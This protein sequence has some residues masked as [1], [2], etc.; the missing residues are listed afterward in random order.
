MPSPPPRSTWSSATPSSSRS[1][2]S[3]TMRAAALVRGSSDVIWEPTW[4]CTPTGRSPSV[5]AA[6][7]KRARADS[8]GTPNLLVRSPVEM[9]GWLRASMSGFTRRAT[10]ALVRWARARPP[11]RS[12]SPGDSALI[13]CTPSTIARSSS[14]GRLA[15]AGEDDAGWIEPGSK[16]DFDLPDGVC[17]GPAAKLAQQ[18]RNGQRR[19][20]LERIVE[21]VR[22]AAQCRVQLAVGGADRR[23]IVDV[24]G[25]A[26]GGGDGVERERGRRLVKWSLCGRCHGSS[27]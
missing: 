12:S 13:V 2:T 7:R 6:S 17:V 27:S 22:H 25:R 23:C 10:R 9:C 26:D 20:G 11:I 15:D 21:S 8:I 16:R 5:A 3:A 14:V 1:S 19:V 24:R 18:P 4:T